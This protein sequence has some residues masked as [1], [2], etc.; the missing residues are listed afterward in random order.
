MDGRRQERIR[1]RLL[2]QDRAADRDVEL[3]RVSAMPPDVFEGRTSGEWKAAGG[4]GA[5]PGE[6]RMTY[7]N[8]VTVE[9][10][11]QL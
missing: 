1:A 9:L 5:D 7:C 2:L 10:S 6:E 4:Q 11:R 3:Q 8:I